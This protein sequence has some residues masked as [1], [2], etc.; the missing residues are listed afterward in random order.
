M[1]R[2]LLN[3]GENRWAW[4]AVIV[5][6][7]SLE[8]GALFFQEVLHYYPCELCIY[9][10]VWMTSLV[11]TS[12]VALVLLRYL[13]ARRLLIV[14]QLVF[15]F[16]LARVTWKLLGFEYGWGEDGACSL[17]ANFPS[18][19]P[20]DTW[21]PVLFKVQ[22]SCAAT[23]LVIGSLSMADGLL[24]TAFGFFIAFTFALV[25]QFLPRK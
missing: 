24:V 22:D 3:L 5:I 19:L 1:I 17:V 16:L 6:C 11:L 4:L 23:P 21:F 2:F 18:W 7:L 10:R 9:T 15:T 13:W 8:G 25:G 20:L 14:V 12:I